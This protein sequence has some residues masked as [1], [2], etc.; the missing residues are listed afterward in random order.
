MYR[1]THTLNKKEKKGKT[2]GRKTEERKKEKQGYS[3][4][5]LCSLVRF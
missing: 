3:G 1:Y 5:H 4:E 2:G